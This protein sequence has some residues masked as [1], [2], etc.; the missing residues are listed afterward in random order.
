MSYNCRRCGESFDHV[1]RVKGANICTDCKYQR[2]RA[3]PEE[4][5][6]WDINLSKT[7]LSKPIKGKITN[8]FKMLDFILKIARRFT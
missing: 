2:D 4:K 5:Q 1:K 6:P 3:D 7:W 8:R